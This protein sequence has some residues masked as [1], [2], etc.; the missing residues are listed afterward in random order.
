MNALGARRWWALV[1][2]SLSLLAVGLDLTVL[3]LALPTLAGALHAS[4][5]DLQWFVAAYSLVLSAALLPG[6]LLGDRF[7]RRKM[8]IIALV[9]FGIGS[10]ACAYAPSSGAL[11]AARVLLGL[12]AAILMPVSLS[13]LPVLFS[14]AERPRAIAVWGGATMLAYPLGPILGGWLLT[15]YWWGSVFL[16][17]VP[18]V[19]IA[20][21]AVVTLLPESRGVARRLDAIGVVLSSLGL[22]GLTYG[23]IEAGQKGWGDP[24]V[25]AALIGGAL[26]LAAFVLWEARATQPLVDLRLFRSPAFTWGTTLA[27]VMGFAMTGAF[28]ALPLYFQEVRGADAL[29]SGF[30]LLPLIGGLVVGLGLGSRV[31]PRLGAKIVVALGFALLA[32]GVGAGATTEVGSGDGFAVAWLAV[33]GVGLGFILPAVMDAALGALAPEQS[34]VGSALITALRMVGGTFGVALLGAV[35]NSAYRS[36]LDLRALPAPVADAVQSSVA[37]GVAVAQRLG[38]PAL[39]ETVRAAYVYGMDVM[40]WVCAGIAV[41]GAVL[42]LI[43]LPRRSGA[44]R[45]EAGPVQVERGGVALG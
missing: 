45:T 9:L 12:G 1:A 18:V 28:F 19:L 24:G 31:G 37:A 8:L 14:D 2:L 30:R 36:Q 40:L 43:F 44:A 38:S 11:I 16:I 29:G 34:G 10:V 17:N 39:L 27:T 7:G 32:L 25:I 42:A 6:G 20:L 5:S 41:A 21:V 35:L 33:A 23:V 3:N 4:T 26:A 22:V 13:V 15:N